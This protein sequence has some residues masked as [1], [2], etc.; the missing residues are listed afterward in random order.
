M[1]FAMANSASAF[2]LSNGNG[3]VNAT[4]FGI[5]KMEHGGIILDMMISDPNVDM[6]RM[7]NP[8]TKVTL[9]DSED[10]F[11]ESDSYRK[12]VGNHRW[13]LEFGGFGEIPEK[14]EIKRVRI[15]PPV[16]NP[17][18]IDWTGVPEI[19]NDLVALKFYGFKNELNEDHSDPTGYLVSTW[20][21]DV[22]ITNN[23]STNL[24]VKERDFKIVDQFGSVYETLASGLQD[25]SSVETLLPKESMRVNIEF[26]PVSQLSRPVY[27]IYE[28]LNQK[29]DISAWS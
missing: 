23:D 27:L 20:T 5:I 1:L 3:D 29:M 25:D 11:Y 6:S 4:V 24:E 10:K 13:Y 26:H 28:P 18:S 9:V 7:D 21:V 2:P 22:K 16:G 8:E 14:A 19:K 12:N 15:S 17:F